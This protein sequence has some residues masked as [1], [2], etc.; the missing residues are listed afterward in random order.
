MIVYGA[1]DGIVSNI[2]AIDLI[3]K[4]VRLEGF[5]L[6]R[7]S[8]TLSKDER[9]VLVETVL[10]WMKSGAFATHVGEK[11]ELKDINLAIEASKKPGKEGKVLVY[12][13]L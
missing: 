9:K 8:H 5:W 11:F 6:S 1:M 2:S 13:K 10:S 12:T 4:G 3:F 7:L